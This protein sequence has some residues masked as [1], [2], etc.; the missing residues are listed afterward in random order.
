MD[1]VWS[2][3]D[4]EAK[5][6]LVVIL[7]AEAGKKSSDSYSVASH[8][9]RLLHSSLILV[10]AVHCCR[11]SCSKLEDISNLYALAAL[12]ALSAYRA[13]ISI[14]GRSDVC[15]HSSVPVSAVVCVEKVI[16]LFVGSCNKIAGISDAVINAQY[17]SLLCSDWGSEAWNHA[18]FL[19][20]LWMG[21]AKSIGWR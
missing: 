16:S 5:A 13:D 17:K 3:C 11:I 4:R 15:N 7:F 12:E 18:I 19:D 6:L 20:F 1:L 14:L 9:Y 2:D 21:G 8:N 10:C